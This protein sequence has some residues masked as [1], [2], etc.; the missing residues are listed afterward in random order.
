MAISD[1][2]KT[3]LFESLY[4]RLRFYLSDVVTEEEAADH[5]MV[6]GWQKSALSELHS[7]WDDDSVGEATKRVVLDIIEV[8]YKDLSERVANHCA[9]HAAACS[10]CSSD[11]VLYDRVADELESAWTMPK[12][13]RYLS[14]K[15][16]ELRI[17][18]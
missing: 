11:R 4:R 7:S 10:E 8:A 6:C 15:Q 1:V 16:P 9:A 3:W 13:T 2:T 17:V 12:V 5:A 18:Q 14:G